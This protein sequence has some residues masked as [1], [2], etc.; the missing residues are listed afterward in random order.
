MAPSIPRCSP[1]S[2][3][4]PLQEIDLLGYFSQGPNAG[5]LVSDT[6]FGDVVASALS[7][8]ASGQPQL[9]AT[10]AAI[11]LQSKGLTNA[12]SQTVEPTGAWNAFANNATF[13]TQAGAGST[14]PQSEPAS[15]PGTGVSTGTDAASYYVRLYD[16]SG[17]AITV[18]GNS[19]FALP[20]FSFDASRVTNIVNDGISAGKLSLDPLDLTLTD[21]GLNSGL[22]AHLSGAIAFSEI[23]VLGYGS[24]DGALLSDTSFGDVV[25]S[26]LDLT[27]SGSADFTANYGAVEL[28]H[29]S[30]GAGGTLV[31]DPV[32]SFDAVTNTANFSRTGTASAA[33]FAAPNSLPATGLSAGTPA[34]TYVARLI[35][36]DGTTLTAGG[37]QLFGL[38][39]F[40]LD[41]TNPATLGATLGAPGRT[42]LGVAT[43][44]FGD[45]TIA[46]TLFQDVANGA[47]LG[48]IDI[49]GY[50]SATGLLVTDDSLGGVAANT[51]TT[52]ISG[53]STFSGTVLAQE[54]Q[55]IGTNGI[56]SGSAS[57][58]EATNAAGF[59]TGPGAPASPAP[60]PTVLPAS[61]VS[62]ATPQA[63]DS[64]VRF[65]NTDGST[66]TVDGNTL[67]Q[68]ADF[69]TD[70][71]HGVSGVTTLDPLALTLAAPSLD[72]TLLSTLATTTPFR[73]VDVLGYRHADGLL[74]SDDSF[75]LVNGGALTIDSTGDAQYSLQYGARSL[76]YSAN[77][78][79]PDP[80]PNAATG[81]LTIGHNQSRN[82][83]ALVNGLITPGV[84]G[85]TETITAVTGHA[86][87]TAGVVTY[88]APTTGPDSFAYTVT[89]Q[90]GDTATG[91]VNVTVDPGPATA[92]G[93]L[94]IGHNQTSNVT[95]L[96]SGLVTPGLPGDSE[97]ITSVSGN[98]TLTA[99]VITYLAPTAGPDSFAYTVTDQLG[100]TATGTVNVT[101]DPGPATA[102]GALTIGH[103]Q[104][105]NVT[106]LVNALVTPGLTGDTDTITAVSSHAT[107]TAG[108]ITYVA[109]A[110]GPDSFTYTVTD[111]HGDT[112]TGRVNVTVDP[113]PA[114]A[115]GALTIG[116]DQTS[117]V[118]A[119]LTGL[120]TP[121][122]P[123]DTDTI[124][125]V[126]GHATLTAGAVTYLAPTTGP[127][128]F[129]Y[130]VTDQ[131]GDTATGTVNVTVDPGPATAPGALTIG[132]N[133][134]SNV[135]ALLTGLIT[136]GLPG[137]TDTITAVTGHATLTA[138]VVTYVAPATGPDSFTYTVTDQLGDTATG[139]VN[140]TVDPGPAAATGALTIGHGQSTNVTSLVNALVTPGLTGD[141][142]TITA[143]SGHA[144]LTAGVVTYV[145][146]ATGPDSFTYTVTD[147]L[148]DTA[149]G[150]VNV[151]VDPGPAAATGALT[152]G[153]GQSTNVTSLVNALVTPGL[154]GDTDTIT[155]VS[156]HATL[157]AGVVTYVAPATGPDSFTYTVT[158]QLGDTATGTVNVTVD[159]GPATATGALTIGHGQST[160]VTSLVNALVTPGLT[161]DTDTI[162]AVSGHATLTAGIITYVAP[163]TGPDSFT[164]T[165]TDQHGD[166]AIGTVNVTVDPGPTAG[167]LATT[168]KLGATANLT[169]AILGVDT[170]GLPDDTLTL[171]AINTAATAGAVTLVNGQLT[172]TASGAA[173]Q[174]I[175]ANGSITDSFGYTVTDQLGE[176]ASATV[177][178][179]VTNPATPVN[180]PSGGFGTI[181]GTP[182]ADVITAA[183]LFN[184]IFDNGGNDLVNAGQALAT[185]Y[186]NTGD[187][188]VN[189]S[190]LGNT[191]QGFPGSGAKATA[192]ADGNVTV[193]GTASLNQIL[194]GNGNDTV[195]LTGL[196][197]VINLGNGNDTVTLAGG[198]NT[199]TLG[200][201]NDTVNASTGD[202]I[203]ISATH[204]LLSGG[205]NDQV[206]VNAG[207]SSI[208]D[209]SIGTTAIIGPAGGNLAI[210]DFA[211]DPTAIL[212]LVGGAGGYRNVAAVLAALKTDGAGGTLLPI[213]SGSTATSI[214]FIATGKSVL[215]A[216]HFR[217]G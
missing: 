199:V 189:L 214:D 173:L 44:T 167:K 215:T 31:A 34:L 101:V 48:E 7:L 206:F 195:T 73:E 113:G 33:P 102:T 198:G 92:T 71:T 194:L 182:G 19:L 115:T 59:A 160:N 51:L 9:S 83:T 21:T 116:H 114:T 127:D 53:L 169:A 60:A 172:Y 93:A 131:L 57:W 97:T 15:L 130:T 204:L 205:H 159:P 22:F 61:G 170:P 42:D 213:G 126:T 91:T 82:V 175:P 179:T 30:V 66:L 50:N 36:A 79:N 87:L 52:D 171:T 211:T 5:L 210:S 4:R 203:Q 11:E 8:D 141:T 41:P 46:P 152:I 191:V 112:A 49:L 137:D 29:N 74:L 196:G 84:P 78:L 200:S 154:T 103:G 1:S 99:G 37:N 90:L 38:T 119:L 76:S 208:D 197:N 32:S 85:D 120:I 55:Q 117:N 39:G 17:V 72:P 77:G 177:T 111:Q 163:A 166:S 25:A 155:A 161:G 142:D 217:I 133:Q 153:H 144:T 188:V 68:L 98:A 140:V 64:Y 201:G 10:F 178:V 6:S 95:A 183:G 14:I 207:P 216:A 35:A 143:V 65:I 202:T 3:P 56:A 148:G 186:V 43:L 2:A 136:P 192:G 123:G 193:R 18:N 157:T 162:T 40:T 24:T 132:H 145:A 58:D 67:F 118:T 86:T 158:D 190:G 125:S 180:G 96:L 209:R 139:T 108:I 184:T 147:Q 75:G 134:T 149:T 80:G 47:V 100:D 109:P 89:D 165:V 168:D 70:A 23:D 110:T 124:S 212:D 63:V 54:V 135:T 106:S 81:S 122:L 150:T 13:Q 164:Y 26:T 94:T 16:Q 121:G 187:V 28:Q 12:G 176:S 185:V 62:P 27:N 138:G 88:L 20:A 129:A 45:A 174:H 105:T 128:S 181:E 104:S 107:L 156:G 151:T 69:S 146:P